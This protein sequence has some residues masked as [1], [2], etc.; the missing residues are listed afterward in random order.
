VSA[1]IFALVTG[2]VVYCSLRFRARGLPGE[3]RQ[4]YGHKRLEILWTVVPFLVLVYLFVL[5]VKAMQ[6][7]D[8]P[9]S[10]EA[11]VVVIGHQFWWEVRYPKAGIVT[12]NE[13][14][15]PAGRRVLFRLEAADVIHDFWVPQWGRKVDL[16]PE[17]PHYIWLQADRPGVYQGACAEFCGTQHAWMRIRAVAEPEPDHERWIQQQQAS[18]TVAATQRGAELFRE[19]TCVNCHVIR[20][21]VPGLPVGPDLTHLATRAT[22]GAGVIDNT[23]QN[24]FRWVRNSQQIKA[25]NLMPAFNLTDDQTSALVS[26]LETLR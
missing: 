20:G 17:Q 19:L 3:P 2:L 12:A 14:H 23:P 15:I 16:I 6:A 8:P 5:T 22:L 4:I 7:S 1:V 24:L 9:K 11:E 10:G 25:G 18:A 21:A 26:Y 13:V